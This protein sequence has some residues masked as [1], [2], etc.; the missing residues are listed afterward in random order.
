MRTGH[1]KEMENRIKEQQLDLFAGLDELPPISGETSSDQAAE[2]G[3]LRLG[4]GVASDGV[5]GERNLGSKPRWG[6]SD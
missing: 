3:G 4:P 1:R 5:F 2:F 6:R